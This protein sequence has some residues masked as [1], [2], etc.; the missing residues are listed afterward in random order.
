M[1]D[2]GKGERDKREGSERQVTLTYVYHH[3]MERW[4]ATVLKGRACVLSD[5]FLHGMKFIVDLVEG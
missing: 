5:L 3:C 1:V 2:L 4:S